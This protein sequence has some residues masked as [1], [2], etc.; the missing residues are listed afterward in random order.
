MK[1]EQWEAFKDAV[2]KDVA[3]QYIKTDYLNPVVYNAIERHKRLLE[4]APPQ[5]HSP[6]CAIAVNGRHACSCQSQDVASGCNTLQDKPT[7]APVVCEWVNDDAMW[8]GSCGIVWEFPHG[9]PRDNDVNFC[10]K[11]G[12]PVKVK[13]G[14]R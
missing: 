10:P 11:C 12:L 1:P 6:D 5:A 9:G 4:D 8:E 14:G 13:G 3:G 7:C 2:A